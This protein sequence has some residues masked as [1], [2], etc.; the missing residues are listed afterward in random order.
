MW[1]VALV[2]CRIG[3][4]P[5]AD[6]GGTTDGS[7]GGT[8]G[9]GDAGGDTSNVDPGDVD[10]PDFSTC[11]TSI[12]EAGQAACSGGA[13]VLTAQSANVRGAAWIGTRYPITTTTRFSIRIV[14]ELRNTG[15]AGDGLAIVLQN[16]TRGANALGLGGGGLGYENITPSLALEVDT[17]GNP[18]E[19]QSQHIGIDRD[20]VVDTMLASPAPFSLTTGNPFTVWFDYDGTQDLAR[21][22]V[23]QGQVTTQPGTATILTSDDLTRVGSSVLVGLTVATGAS[24]QTAHRVLSWRV[25]VTP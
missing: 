17:F 25:D 8:D 18:G 1:V 5:L 20:G 16:D 12:T 13:L 11:P 6:D 10:Y 14:V 23:A 21:G 24:G 19:P 2:G 7:D 15:L 3:F 22:F 9:K 4:D